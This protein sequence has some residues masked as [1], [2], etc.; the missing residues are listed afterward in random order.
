MKR[1]LTLALAAMMIV[2]FAIPAFAAP[3]IEITGGRLYSE[4]FFNAANPWGTY[5]PALDYG[6]KNARLNFKY[7][8]DNFTA[9]Y[10]IDLLSFYS[11]NFSLALPYMNLSADSYYGTVTLESDD[12]FKELAGFNWYAELEEDTLAFEHLYAGVGTEVGD[13]YANLDYS[14]CLADTIHYGNL[15][16]GYSFSEALTVDA[17]VA[18]TLDALTDNFA[19][20]VTVGFPI[21]DGWTG[22]FYADYAMLNAYADFYGTN[23]ELYAE[24]DTRYNNEAANAQ[25]EAS[26][27][28][29]AAFGLKGTVAFNAEYLSNGPV[30]EDDY[31]V[32]KLDNYGVASWAYGSYN[33]RFN[34]V[35]SNSGNEFAV[36]AE[37]SFN[38][39]TTVLTTNVYGMFAPD[40]VPM[41][42]IA[43]GNVVADF[44]TPA[45]TWSVDGLLG[46]RITPDI[47]YTVFGKYVP[48]TPFK[49]DSSLVYSKDSVTCKVT[50]TDLTTAAW[51]VKLFTGIKF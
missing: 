33:D 17:N 5:D 9:N 15:N 37:N 4:F 32:K 28:N 27:L 7:S 42:V 34:W 48:A 3:K 40:V 23:D 8:A 10:T 2:A 46:L 26:Y 1:I 19:F 25:V 12:K 30:S 44:V 47:H 16:L 43:H 51:G 20:D 36:R 11:Y 22:T 18:K 45:T 13:F 29:N 50:G 35:R 21:V 38:I 49:L 41:V 31:D 24:V 14:H 39:D 6:L